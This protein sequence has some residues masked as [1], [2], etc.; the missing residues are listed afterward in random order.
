[1]ASLIQL[2]RNQFSRADDSIANRRRKIRYDILERENQ[3]GLDKTQLN[4]V[5]ENIESLIK[6]LS[7]SEKTSKEKTKAEKEYTKALEAARK[8]A[9]ERKKARD[10]GDTTREDMLNDKLERQKDKLSALSERRKELT[11]EKIELDEDLLK[12]LQKKLK[13]VYN[14]SEQEVKDLFTTLDSSKLVKL[15]KTI[16]ADANKVADSIVQEQQKREAFNK[17][18]DSMFG[19]DGF[20]AVTTFID[21]ITQD[22]GALGVVIRRLMSDLLDANKKLVDFNRSLSLGFSS[23]ELL[24]GDLYG[25]NQQYGLTNLKREM[26]ASNLG[27]DDFLNSFKAFS[28]GNI[29]GS[30]TQE[31]GGSSLS[32]MQFGKTSALLSKQYGVEMGNLNAISENLFYNFGTNITDLNKILDNGRKIAHQ[33]GV[34]VKGYYENLKQ[35]TDALGKFYIADGT[36][37][38]EQLALSASK[39]GIATNEVLSIASKYN[40]FTS[41]FEIQGKAMALGM[42]NFSEASRAIWALNMTGQKDKAA[43]LEM[44]T[45]LRDFRNMGRF[46]NEGNLNQAGLMTA[47]AMG[48]SEEQ[49]KAI[50]R[51]NQKYKEL[52][53]KGFTLEDITGITPLSKEKQYALEKYEKNNLTAG[54]RFTASMTKIMKLF[55]GMDRLLTPLIDVGLSLV[56]M[57]GDVASVV[58]DFLVPGFKFFGNILGRVRDAFGFLGDFISAGADKLKGLNDI[59]NTGTGTMS[60]FLKAVSIA[61]AALL[62]Y[63]L[64]GRG[65]GLVNGFVNKGGKGIKFLPKFMRKHLLRRLG[66][67]RYKNAYMGKLGSFF[68]KIPK[69]RLI[70]GGLGIVGNLIGSA[71][72][73]EAGNTI[74]SISTGAG[75]GMMMGGPMGAALGTGI[76]I[77]VSAGSKI[78]SV[79]QDENASVG[80][81]IGRTF[82]AVGSTLKD[83]FKGIINFFWDLPKHLVNII[84]GAGNFLKK[85]W[86][87]IPQFF[88]DM[89]KGFSDDIA[90]GTEKG[91]LNA[92]NKTK[93]YDILS[94]LTTGTMYSDKANRI[95]EQRKQIVDKGQMTQEREEQ[96]MKENLTISVNASSSL[97]GAS[98]K[99]RIQMAK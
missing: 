42:R 39:L 68:N 34:S 1:M 47:Q 33:A 17:R 81:K 44:T 3:F 43:A 72:G 10:S 62:T 51:L 13:D 37:G 80:R 76:G 69:S 59:M 15:L 92:N 11:E 48:L 50:S 74:S 30:N 98:T 35:A 57:F 60:K 58:G 24:G 54:E 9:R 91:I 82:S 6:F 77:I 19:E 14:M 5:N 73:G 79:W 61:G 90:E 36:R 55:G 28:K 38:L 83:A 75:I 78:A 27:L 85:L 25:N 49:I 70:G 63:S 22:L 96:R 67:E 71:V 64:L 88:S 86:D 12:P 26:Q 93:N 18:I 32:A 97:Y 40:N 52:G 89:V 84:K 56:E 53:A 46:D 65:G 16:S 31:V 23:A 2:L 4:A 20:R 7:E 66:T 99:A 95:M 41:Q 29:L 45:Q 87:G 21:T 94:A 8:F